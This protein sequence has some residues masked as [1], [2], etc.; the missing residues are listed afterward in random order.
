MQC[1]IIVNFKSITRFSFVWPLYAN[2]V[3]WSSWIKSMNNV[4]TQNCV[5]WQTKSLGLP[6]AKVWRTQ[7]VLDSSFWVFFKWSKEDDPTMTMAQWTFKPQNEYNS[8]GQMDIFFFW[9]NQAK[10]RKEL[11]FTM[12]RHEVSVVPQPILCFLTCHQVSFPFKPM[13]TIRKAVI[14][15]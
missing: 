12:L 3:F 2:S 7:S 14:F 5:W 11:F 8:S 9:S 4:F 13:P 15:Y 1:K 6:M 10:V